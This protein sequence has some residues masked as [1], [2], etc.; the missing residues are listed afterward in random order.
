ML[1]LKSVRGNEALVI[2][3]PN[4]DHPRQPE[5]RRSGR[6]WILGCGLN[7][8]SRIPLGAI[9]VPLESVGARNA[10]GIQINL[11][12]VAKVIN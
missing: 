4:I 11:K 10:K 3:G 8:V 12:A 6:K 2:S 1:H 5:I 9:T 7:K